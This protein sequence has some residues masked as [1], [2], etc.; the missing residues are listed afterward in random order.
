MP[1][2]LKRAAYGGADV[3][4]S[5]VWLACPPADPPRCA[6][7]GGRARASRP[8]RARWVDGYLWCPQAD[9]NV[10]GAQRRSGQ[11]GLLPSSLRASGGVSIIFTDRHSMPA[12]QIGVAS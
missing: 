11:F 7:P 8:R 4:A 1:G 10:V 3:V 5:V 2:V 9:G 6:R 12:N